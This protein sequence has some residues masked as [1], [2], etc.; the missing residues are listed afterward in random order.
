MDNKINWK[1]HDVDYI[2]GKVSSAIGMI[3]KARKFLTYESLKSLY[4][5]FVYPFLIYC[6][7]VWGNE[8]STS[9]KNLV[10]LQKKTI[11]IIYGVN[12]RTSCDPLFEES[13]FLRFANINKYMIARFMYGTWMIF[14]I[15]F[16]IILHQIL[17]YIIISQDRV[18]GSSFQLSRP[19]LGKHAWLIEVLTFGIRY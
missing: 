2:A 16:I 18:I 11:R 14:L 4:Y 12:S 8:C 13:A 1:R 19:T 6:N 9:L 7:H 15:Y 17:L 5:S 10:L 3:A